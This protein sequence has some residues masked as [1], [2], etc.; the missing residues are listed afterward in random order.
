MANARRTVSKNMTILSPAGANALDA[1]KVPVALKSLATGTLRLRLR[2]VGRVERFCSQ[3]PK[4]RAM[5][6]EP[7]SDMR[8]NS[9][10]VSAQESEDSEDSIE[11]NKTRQGVTGHNVRYVLFFGIAG[12]IVGFVLVYLIVG[13]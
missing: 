3:P 9:P 13:G 7:R 6:S 5:T 10:S 2:F 4:V 1:G 12:V 11:T 8:P